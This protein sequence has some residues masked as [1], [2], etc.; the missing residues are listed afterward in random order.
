MA[1]TDDEWIRPLLSWAADKI[2]VEAV[3]RDELIAAGRARLARRRVLAGTA[4]TA[5]LAFAL[6]GYAIA[7]G[8]GG[9]GRPGHVAV[10]VSATAATS[11]AAPGT[12]PAPAVS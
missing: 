3:G 5:V 6:G 2:E 11:S 12:L 9:G 7:E 1:E 10:T 8:V 4:L